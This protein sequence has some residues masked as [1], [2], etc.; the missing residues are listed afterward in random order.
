[1]GSAI[2]ALQD[3]WDAAK[4]DTSPLGTEVANRAVA[5][6]AELARK[7]GDAAL[8]E[9]ILTEVG[10]APLAAPRWAGQK[11]GYAQLGY[12]DLAQEAEAVAPAAAVALK[13]LLEASGKGDPETEARLANL[14]ATGPIP[15]LG[16]IRDQ[17]GALGVPL[18]LVQRTA[19]GRSRRHRLRTFASAT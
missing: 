8:L 9:Q 4:T 7:L 16:A 3:A 2:S 10:G 17:S 13:S 11:L 15:T 1:M 12:A 14:R 18:Q 6:W 5:E 19:R